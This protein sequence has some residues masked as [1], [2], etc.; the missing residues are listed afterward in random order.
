MDEGSATNFDDLY[1][2]MKAERPI[3]LDFSQEPKKPEPTLDEARDD[4]A[5][6]VS[7]VAHAG[8]EVWLVTAA[9][10]DMAIL[11]QKI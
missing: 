8:E 3:S 1:S 9:P 11:L 4:L 10:E 2:R 6:S 5:K 7:E